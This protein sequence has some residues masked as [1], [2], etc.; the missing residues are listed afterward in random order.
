[1]NY[2]EVK[3]L[4]NEVVPFASHAG[5]EVKNVDVGSGEAVLLDKPEAKNHIG[6]QHA[7]ALFTLGEA[8]SGAAMIGAFAEHFGRVRPLVGNA[9]IEYHAVAKGEILARAHLPLPGSELVAE[10]EQKR[11]IKFAVNVTMTDEQGKQVASMVV[12]WHLSLRD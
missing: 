7:G 9:E 2:Q 5:V 10:L 8:A 1:M 6:S 11:A 3:T 12:H 4:L